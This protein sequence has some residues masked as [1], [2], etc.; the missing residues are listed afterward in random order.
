LSEALRTLTAPNRYASGSV[1]RAMSNERP[2]Q[3]ALFSD[4]VVKKALPPPI[5]LPQRVA[6]AAVTEFFH[7]DEPSSDQTDARV[8]RLLADL[9]PLLLRETVISAAWMAAIHL[10]FIDRFDLGD[11][12]EMLQELGLILAKSDEPPP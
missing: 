10:R 6:L 8:R 1:C 12:A 4:D 9:P 5:E 11:A 7:A 2:R 3:L